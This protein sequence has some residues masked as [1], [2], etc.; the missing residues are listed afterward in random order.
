MGSNTITSSPK[1]AMVLYT[2]GGCRQQVGGWG[3]HGYTYPVDDSDD[4]KKKKK[5]QVGVPTTDGYIV[6]DDPELSSRVVVRPHEVIEAFGGILPNTTN[7]VAELS[8]TLNGMKL[9]LDKQAESLLIYSDSEYVGKGVTSYLKKWRANNWKKSDGSDVANKEL[10]M[11]LG[12]YRDILAQKN[13]RFTM[14]WVKGHA[15]HKGN[16][17]ADY[18]ATRGV[19]CARAGDDT[20]HVQIQD[21]GEY[22]KYKTDRPRF[23][24]HSRWYFNVGTDQFQKN[25]YGYYEYNFG[26]PSK[27]DTDQVYLGKALA[28]TAYSVVWLKKPESCLDLVYART[29]EIAENAFGNVFIGR[30][31]NIY[32]PFNHKEI[33]D[34]GASLLQRANRNNNDVVC[35]TGAPI[36]VECN[37]PRISYRAVSTL[38]FLSK[39]L[40]EFVKGELS[41]FARAYD[42]C[43]Y[44]YEKVESKKKTTLQIV[45]SIKQTTRSVSVKVDCDVIDK[46]I[47]VPITLTF[48]L[49]IPI[50]NTL[51]GIVEDDP[52]VYV[53]LYRE[54]DVA[55]R[56]FTITVCNEGYCLMGDVYANLRI[57]SKKE[58]ESCK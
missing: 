24:S 33:M 13:I 15:G 1:V 22:D 25:Q 32:N 2:D 30:L 6:K 40:T 38:Q 10:W 3:I 44:I 56:Y 18:M 23:I 53:L 27:D 43:D 4:K 17:L 7:N 47:T 51:N 31:D 52:K 49:D 5:P 28:D 58:L 26:H 39:L 35:S 9:A 34:F 54:S 16:M 46:K 57:L 14:Q 45:K 11:E 8:A 50:R 19:F 42:I 20:N 41:P 29:R 21:A 36:V 12:N 37:P 48:G 55:F